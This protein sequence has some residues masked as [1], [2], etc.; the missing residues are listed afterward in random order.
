MGNKKQISIRLDA[1]TRMLID[2]LSGITGMN[3]SV[4]VRSMVLRCVE[5]L[6]D[7]SGNW[8]LKN[9]KSQEGENKP[10]GLGR[11]SP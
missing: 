5:E 7:K 1:R 3:R 8:K 9:E 4:I 11:N 2:E 6:I 10:K